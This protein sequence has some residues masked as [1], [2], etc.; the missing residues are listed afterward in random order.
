MLVSPSLEIWHLQEKIQDSC[1]HDHC[2]R[3]GLVERLLCSTTY[4][5]TH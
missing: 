5:Y 1:I 4:V 3:S 2:K